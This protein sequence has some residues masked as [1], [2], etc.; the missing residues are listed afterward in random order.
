MKKLMLFLIVIL[1]LQSCVQYRHVPTYIPPTRQ[2][3]T[4]PRR[5]E[6][7][8]NRVPPRRHVHSYRYVHPHKCTPPPQR[9]RVNLNN[10]YRR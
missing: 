1:T 2:C 4:P 3:Y 6:C 8:P 5:V 10:N 9:P 7:F